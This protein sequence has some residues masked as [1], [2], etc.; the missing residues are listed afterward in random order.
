ML[1]YF[2]LEIFG[3]EISGYEPFAADTI[4]VMAAPGAHRYSSGLSREVNDDTT[5]PNAR[6]GGYPE[7]VASIPLHTAL[8][9]QDAV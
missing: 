2:G 1:L 3:A 5:T 4:W 7:M 8:Q 6:A 9:S